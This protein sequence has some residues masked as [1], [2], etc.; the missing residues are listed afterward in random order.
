MA[1]R[2]H[3]DR[4]FGY[5]FLNGANPVAL[6]RCEALPSNFPVTNEHVNASLDRGKN[7]DEEIKV[8]VDQYYSKCITNHFYLASP[9]EQGHHNSM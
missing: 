3:E 6:T 7:L 8:G 2:W 9:K 1:D 5:K 4:W